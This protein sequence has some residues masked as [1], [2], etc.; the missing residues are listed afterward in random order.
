MPDL[1][2][3]LEEDERRLHTDPLDPDEKKR[4]EN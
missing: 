2:K 3:E 1:Y 4:Y